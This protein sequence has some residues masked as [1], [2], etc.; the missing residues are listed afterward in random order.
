V[1][2][3]LVRMQILTAINYYNFYIVFL[4]LVRIRDVYKLIENNSFLL[5]SFF[6]FIILYIIFIYHIYYNIYYKFIIFIIFIY[7]C[8]LYFFILLFYYYFIYNIALL[9]IINILPLN[10]IHYAANEKW[11]SRIVPGN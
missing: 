9:C 7:S 10:S 6:I 1:P 5:Y 8:L 3:S 2:L 4:I 11:Y